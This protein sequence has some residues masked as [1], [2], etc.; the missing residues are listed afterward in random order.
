MKKKY[1]SDADCI[2]LLYNAAVTLTGVHQPDKIY[3]LIVAQSC[4]L[5]Q[6]E[7]GFIYVV[8]EENEMLEVKCG[9]GIYAVYNGACRS[10][11]E[12]S[13]SSTVWRTGRPLVVESV[14]DWKGHAVDRPYG[15][16]IIK[17]V[18]GIPLYSGIEVI[19]VIGLGFCDQQRHFNLLEIDLLSRFAALASLALYNAK[20]YQNPGAQETAPNNSSPFNTD[21][22]AQYQINQY[23]PAPSCQDKHE[24]FTNPCQL[25]REMWKTAQ[26]QVVDASVT[27]LPPKQLPE[28]EPCAYRLPLTEREQTVLTML[29]DGASNQEISRNL[30]VAIPTVKAHISHIFAKLGAKRRVQAIIIGR[31][32]GLL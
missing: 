22:S 19:A 11:E 12:P 20:C 1:F 18:L 27:S 15:W 24:D 5:T 6:T 21:F 31:Q 4:L 2:D 9:T 7:N 13:V 10:K 28:K 17:S 16:D 26:F 32:Q 30:S 29:A 14:A 8:N 23:H 25:A 3:S